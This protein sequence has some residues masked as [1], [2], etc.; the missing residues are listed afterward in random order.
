VYALPFGA[1][2]ILNVPQQAAHQYA[3]SLMAPPAV[4]AIYAAGC[5]QVPLVDLLY[6][7][8]SDV[9][10][11][12]VGQL[13]KQGEGEKAVALFREAARKLALVFIPASAFLV[14]SAPWVVRALFGAKFDAA[15][16][17]FRVSVLGVM[18]ASLPMDGL[19]RARGE[20][21]HLFYAYLVKALVTVPLLAALVPWLGP[22]GGILGW[23]AA[24]L[25]GKAMLILRIPR[26]LA[27]GSRVPALR[28][29]LPVP[30][31]VRIV[32]AT[33]AC[34]AGVLLLA[35][36][37]AGSLLQAER[38]GAVVQVAAAGAVFSAALLAL[39]QLLGLRPMAVFASLR[40]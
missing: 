6:S 1:A 28:E 29:W 5:F 17:I 10:M 27:V 3:V 23:L 32:G 30:E 22:M 7:P 9:L 35:P 12:R 37:L 4:F 26:A 19:L 38:A 18:L 21:K 31:L 11:V 34:S 2:M 16:P 40:R 36:I 33:V 39:M 14:V 25:V 8:T 24:E 15:V 13:D 20:T